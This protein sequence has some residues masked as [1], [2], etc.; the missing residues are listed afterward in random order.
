MA[1]LLAAPATSVVAQVGGLATSTPVLS[2]VAAWNVKAAAAA[3]PPNSLTILI[4]SGAVQSIP[5][6]TDNRINAFPTPVSITTQWDLSTIITF[7]DLVGYF[8]VPTMA[9]STGASHIPS[10][11]VEGRV[12]TGRANTFTPFDGQPISGTGTPGGTLLLF[13]QLIISPFNG[14][15]SRTDNLELQL[16][17]QG[18]PRLEPGVYRGT[19]T[20]RALTY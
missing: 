6:I 16:N 19:L 4:N 3:A 1:I 7:V 17:L 11:R 2:A 20:L 8:S 18:I 13:R 9:L 5:T 10:T 14:S 12:L 15:A